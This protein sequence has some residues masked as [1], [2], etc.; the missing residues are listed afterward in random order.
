MGQLCGRGGLKLW[1]LESVHVSG[2]G[3]GYQSVGLRR[4]T[5]LDSLGKLSWIVLNT[6]R[7]FVCSICSSERLIYIW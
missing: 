1:R 2:A 4:E 5:R 6:E 7:A 3:R